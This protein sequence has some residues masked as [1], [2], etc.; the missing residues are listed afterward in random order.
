MTEIIYIPISFRVQVYS[1]VI[2]SLFERKTN[3]TS[4]LRATTPPGD[5][6]STSRDH[7]DPIGPRGAAVAA[8]FGG[9]D[10]KKTSG[11]FI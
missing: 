2:C 8:K 7:L 3:C 1:T 4:A 6:T 9:R 5:V 10:V 11:P